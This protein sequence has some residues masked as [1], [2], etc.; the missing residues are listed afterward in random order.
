MTVEAH[1]TAGGTVRATASSP[2]MPAR[3][4]GRLNVKFEVPRWARRTTGP[5]QLQAL[6]RGQPGASRPRLL[7]TRLL[8]QMAQADVKVQLTD[9][10]TAELEESPLWDASSR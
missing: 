7:Q 8:L 5:L 1:L 6:V 3:G 9:G 10:G 4:A 2:A